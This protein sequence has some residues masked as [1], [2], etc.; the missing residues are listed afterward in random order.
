MDGFGLAK[1]GKGNAVELS[2]TPNL[3]RLMKTYA[4]T[5]LAAAGLDVGLPDGQMGNSEVGHLNIGG[6]RVVYQDI[7]AIDKNIK[8][9]DFFQNKIFAEALKRA[10]DKNGA[11]H[12][13]GLASDGGVHSHLRH[14]MALLELCKQAAVEKVFVHVITDGRDTAPKS[15]I[16][17]IEQIERACRGV[18]KIAT[19]S[20][21]FYAM[22]RDKRWERIQ[23]AYDSIIDG[24]G[25]R[26]DGAIAAV[27]AS[28][29]KDVTDEF[30]V[31]CV[32]G[33]FAGVSDADSIIF[34]NFRS[35]RAKQISAVISKKRKN[36]FLVTMTPYDE[37]LKVAVAFPPKDI[38][39]TLGDVLSAN[40]RT[41]VRIAE[42][43]KF[44]HVT[45]FFNGTR[46]E[47][48][49]GEERIL[50]PSPKVAVYDSVPEMSAR[51]VTEK[52]LAAVGKYDVMILNFAN[53]DMVGHTG[54][55]P[56]TIAAVETVDECVGKIVDA[57]VASGGVAFVTADHGNAE[58]MLDAD[59]K[60][61]FT[62]HTTNLVPL[63][64]A[65][66]KFKK[67]QAKIRAGRLSDIAP[68]F[69]KILGIDA[70]AEMDGAVLV[71]L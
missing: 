49:K 11:V 23:S 41:Q 18:A 2:R 54:N 43:E 55:I 57:I 47:P 37:A 68:T 22:D 20:G 26:F 51:G 15:A 33:D 6:G 12:L 5:T 19:V 70:P 8:D 56:A 61:P 48:F 29:A 44:A 64:I 53:C 38:K 13:M 65:G 42:T 60:M 17:F 40:G 50:V 27:N 67:G 28:Y 32:V 7:T 1:A 25:E 24:K 21:R 45:S 63:I 9:G 69:L 52:A 35:D 31:P 3:D 46:Q 59:G 71:N 10:K 14:L 39:N 16:P 36:I 34:F 58:Q 62:A 66:E 30:V 4:N